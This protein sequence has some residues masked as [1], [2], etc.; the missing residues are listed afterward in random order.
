[1]F[2]SLGLPPLIYVLWTY[3]SS[4][5][6]FFVCFSRFLC[7]FFCARHFR[8]WEN[9]D[10]IWYDASLSITDR[11]PS[12]IELHFWSFTK[13]VSFDKDDIV[14]VCVYT[15][16]S[17]RLFLLSYH[18]ILC[19][20]FLLKEIFDTLIFLN[21]R[22]LHGVCVS[23][24]FPLFFSSVFFYHHHHQ[25]LGFY[26]FIFVQLEIEL[27]AVNLLLLSE[28]RKKNSLIYANEQCSIYVYHRPITTTTTTKT[29]VTITTSKMMHIC[30]DDCCAPW[31]NDHRSDTKAIR[32]YII[33]VENTCWNGVRSE[34]N[35]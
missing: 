21:G 10:E 8:C 5:Q 23:V 17:K 9:M 31:H 25:I 22:T 14:R 7:S 26:L 16:F 13:R 24:E 29:N 1:M 4:I 3:C 19:F 30:G 20:F 34:R 6:F 12:Q 11:C 2:P 27:L 18:F 35:T 33:C 28:A 15:F 32:I